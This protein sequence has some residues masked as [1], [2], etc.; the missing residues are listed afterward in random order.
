MIKQF[1]NKVISAALMLCL[2]LF[3]SCPVS[4]EEEAVYI[5]INHG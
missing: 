4:A 3:I 5:T 1:Q 2:G